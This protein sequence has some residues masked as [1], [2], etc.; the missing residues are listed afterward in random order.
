MRLRLLSGRSIYRRFDVFEYDEVM[1]LVLS[2][3]GFDWRRIRLPRS[4]LHRMPLLQFFFDSLHGLM[5][6]IS[7]CDRGSL[8]LKKPHISAFQEEI[9]DD[10]ES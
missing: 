7:I 3:F 8:G 9:G 5:D 6:C 4:L 10:L 2:S 1:I